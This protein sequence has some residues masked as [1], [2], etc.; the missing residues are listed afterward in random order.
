MLEATILLI[1]NSEYMRNGDYQPSRFGAQADAVNVVFTSKT[2]A[3]PESTVG[4]MTL[5][6]KAPEVLV[7]PTTNHGKILSALHQSKI[8]GSVDLATGLNVAQLALKHRQNK[9]QRQRIIVFLGSPLDTDEKSLVKL[10]KKL[11]KNNVAVDVISFGEEDINDSLLRTFVDTLN[12]SDNSHLLSIPSGSNMLIS[13]AIL[14][15]PILAGDEG[16]PAAAMGGGEAS[17]SN[18]FEFGVDPSLDPELAMALRISMEEERARQA[19]VAGGGGA[20]APSLPQVP[21]S[22]EPTSQTAAQETVPSME[23]DEEDALLA[24][25]LALSQEEQGDV[26]MEGADNHDMDED[27]N[28][29]EE[30]ARAIEMSVKEEEEQNKGK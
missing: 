19:A 27:L 10:A 3:N 21:E 17:G 20:A 4:L 2:D 16:I 9:N 25:A 24:Q 22:V 23:E 11:K 29:E 14:T 8:G 12:S 26:A 15:S 5:A 13:D 7:T 30:I 28:E 18:Q 6:G 1:D